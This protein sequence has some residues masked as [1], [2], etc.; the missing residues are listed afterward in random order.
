MF[1]VNYLIVNYGL[2]LKFPKSNEYSSPEGT[3]EKN[4]KEMAKKDYK[5]PKMIEVKVEENLMSTVS[6]GNATCG[7]ECVAQCPSDC[8]SDI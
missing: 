1:Y 8:S 6:G 4:T 7:T 5:S 2:T 3:R